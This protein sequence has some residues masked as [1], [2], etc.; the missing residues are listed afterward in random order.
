MP[1]SS[2]RCDSEESAVSETS[3]NGLG[4]IVAQ[5]WRRERAPQPSE[6]TAKG[7]THV[8]A[9]WSTAKGGTHVLALC[10]APGQLEFFVALALQQ[11]GQ[12][13]I[14]REVRG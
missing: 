5:L 1:N 7:G 2:R 4:G 12:Q 3:H 9:L 8:L 14:L 11:H 13:S 6:S 10:T